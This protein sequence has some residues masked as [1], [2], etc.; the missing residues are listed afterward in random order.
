MFEIFG[1]WRA[2]SDRRI[3]LPPTKN[4]NRSPWRDDERDEQRPKHRRAGTNRDRPHVRPHE[5]AHEGH[6][7]HGGDHGEGGEDG[8]IA[9]F[10]HGFHGDGRPVAAFVLRQ[11]EVPDDVFDHHD[12]V[13]H[14]DADAED[15][16]EERDAVQ[17]EAV[18]VK[19]EQRERQRGRN[20]DRD[21]AALP[22]AEREPDEDRHAENG[23]AHVQQQLVGFLRRGLAVV[24]RDADGD[25]GGNDA[26]FEQIDLAQHFVSDA[27]RVR[28]GAFGDAERHGGFSSRHRFRTVEDVLRRLPRPIDDLGDLAQIHRTTAEDADDDIAD[29]FGGFEEGTGFDEDFVVAVVRPPARNWRFACCSI[30]TRPA[31]LRLRLASFTGS[32]NTRTARREPPISVVSATSGTCLMDSSTCAASGAA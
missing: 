5:A 3:L 26:A 2:F 32:S 27:D 1:R 8:G 17:R 20:G 25:I 12:G 30:G 24:A 7:Q 16:R 6:R 4:A 11:M 23:D 29:F 21:D 28:A 9:D 19:N 13:I 18:E 31:G 22:P 15:E 14:E 10:A